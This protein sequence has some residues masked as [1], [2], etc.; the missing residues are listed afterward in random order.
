L[1]NGSMGGRRGETTIRKGGAHYKKGQTTMRGGGSV[2]SGRKGGGLQVGLGG[3]SSIE[4]THLQ[5]G[6]VEKAIP[7]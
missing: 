6:K 2:V 7:G 4:K 1:G 3:G 5:E